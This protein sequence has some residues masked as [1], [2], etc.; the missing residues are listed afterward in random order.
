MPAVRCSI[1]VDMYTCWLKYYTKRA[2]MRYMALRKALFWAALILVVFSSAAVFAHPPK[3]VSLELRPGGE[4]VVRVAHTVD[5]PGKHYISRIVVYADNAIIAT[6]DYKSQSGTGGLT[7]TFSIG[8][9]A[10]G[11]NLKAEAFCV[12]MGSASGSM[13]IP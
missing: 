2:G 1:A 7:D 11:V 8:A 13:V 6:R 10:S 9:A 4:L 12:I 5:D 3:E